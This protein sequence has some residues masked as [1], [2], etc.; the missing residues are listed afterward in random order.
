MFHLCF[1]D[2]CCKCIYL[3]I[4]YIFT[5]IVGVRTQEGPKPTSEFV[6]RVPNL[7]GN[8]KRIHG[9]LSWFGQKKALRP[10]GGVLYLLAPKCLRRGY[11]L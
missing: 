8:A 2:V 7:D 9:G 5:H 3:D 11:K 4:A 1:S 6:L 10:A